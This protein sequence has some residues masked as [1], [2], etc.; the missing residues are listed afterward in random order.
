MNA[1]RSGAEA[2]VICDWRSQWH[3]QGQGQGEQQT[4]CEG[5]CSAGSVL[6]DGVDLEIDYCL[7]VEM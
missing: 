1:T 6:L 2:D 3:S 7:C 4:G 5:G